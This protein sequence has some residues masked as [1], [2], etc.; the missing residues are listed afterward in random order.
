MAW[1]HWDNL[2]EENFDADEDLLCVPKLYTVDAGIGGIFLSYQGAV[3][4]SSLN[5]EV[6]NN[7]I[8]IIL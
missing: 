5:P 2:N 4:Q 1:A 8:V 7:A 6:F 3:Q